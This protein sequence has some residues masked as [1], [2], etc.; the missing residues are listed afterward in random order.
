MSCISNSLSMTPNIPFA[1]FVGTSQIVKE[2][3][4][5]FTQKFSSFSSVLALSNEN[6]K[7]R[8]FRVNPV[9]CEVH[10]G[11]SASSLQVAGPTPIHKQRYDHNFPLFLADL[12]K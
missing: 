5:D 10:R 12:I 11:K 4:C 2:N 1:N 9:L 8:T 7:K 6:I 3:V